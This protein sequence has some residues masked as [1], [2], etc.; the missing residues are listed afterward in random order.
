MINTT[1]LT[2]LLR[3]IMAMYFL[4]L[5]YLTLAVEHVSWNMCVPN[6]CDLNLHLHL[7]TTKG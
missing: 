3:A 1:W 4:K 6:T 2:D 5:D 7:Q